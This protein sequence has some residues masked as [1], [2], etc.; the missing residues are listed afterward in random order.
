MPDLV[1]YQYSP[2]TK[3]TEAIYLECSFFQLNNLVSREQS[4]NKLIYLLLQLARWQ[5]LMFTTY[6]R[7]TPA[8]L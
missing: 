8:S 2:N 7:L 4:K 3:V 5:Q 6:S 1:R